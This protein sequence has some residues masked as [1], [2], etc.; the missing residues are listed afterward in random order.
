MWKQRYGF[1]LFGYRLIA[2]P[3]L[4][5]K[6]KK[7]M[8]M[9]AKSMTF[10]ELNESTTD[11]GKKNFAKRT[12]SKIFRFTR[13]LLSAINGEGVE[14]MDDYRSFYYWELVI[15]LRK[16]ILIIVVIFSNGI[17]VGLQLNIILAILALFWLIQTHSAPLLSKTL[18]HLEI[19]VF[20]LFLV[21]IYCR[22]LL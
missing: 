11:K 9:F 10:L 14:L 22:V 5:S 18:N 7:A 16:V 8:S 19:L 13:I 6:K 20:L 15:Y 21:Y 12:C 4:T 1:A 2:D 3:I 17:N